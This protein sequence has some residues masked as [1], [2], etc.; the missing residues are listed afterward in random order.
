[1][2]RVNAVTQQIAIAFDDDV[3]EMKA[4]AELDAPRRHEIGAPPYR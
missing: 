4:D 1:V 3:A 2:W